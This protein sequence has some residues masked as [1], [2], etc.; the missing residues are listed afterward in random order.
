MLPKKLLLT[1]NH[2]QTFGLISEGLSI[3]SFCTAL[4]FIS[5]EA[6]IVKLV[7]ASSVDAIILVY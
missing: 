4:N 5:L 6:N 3:C 1:G 7:L 2:T